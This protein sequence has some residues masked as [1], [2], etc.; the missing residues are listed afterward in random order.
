MVAPATSSTL[1]KWLIPDIA[2]VLAAITM[3]YCLISFGGMQQFFRDSDSGWHIRNGERVLASGQ[4]P[5]TD[6]FSFSKP[7]GAWFAWEWLAD[8]TMAKAHE[9]DGLRG[10]FLL[11][12]GVLGLVTWLWVQLL[13]TVKTWFL[14]AA[15]SAWVMLTTSSIHWLARPHLYGWVFLLLVVIL[16]ERPSARLN[17]KTILLVFIGS[18]LWANMHASF[19]LGTAIFALYAGEKWLRGDLAWKPLGVCALVSFAA[20]FINPYGW[21]VHQHIISYLQDKEL[22]SRIGEFQTFNF[23][24]DGAEALVVGLVL[25]AVGIG[26]SIEQGNFARGILC[27]VLFTGALRSARGLPLLVLVGLPLALSSICRAIENAKG[28]PSFVRD[29]ANYNANLR[30]MDANFRGYALVPV[31]LVLFVITS[32][33]AL[34]SKPTGFPEGTYPVAL[35]AQIEKLPE[36]ARLFSTDKFGG[37]LIYRFDGRRKVFFDGRSDYYGANFFKDYLLIPEVKPGWEAQWN[38]WNFTHALVPKDSTLT[39]MLPVKGWRQIGK[40]ETAILFEKGSQ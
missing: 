2:L 6:P 32:R 19:F 13:W 33:S 30:K 1:R 3:L 27:L 36:D 24:V 20:G 28:L 26:L 31:L 7:N 29:F 15:V 16:C 38:R 37:Y 22:L 40:D 21:H 9:W 10:V 12:L 17:W 11:Y 18:I 23:H 14:V 34:F 25:V 5:Q 4:V 8:C 35:S 39:E